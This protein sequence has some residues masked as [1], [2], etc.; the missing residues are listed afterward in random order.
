MKSQRFKIYAEIIK[1]LLNF[2]F[3]WL[4]GPSILKTL[5]SR[6]LASNRAKLSGLVG[7]RGLGTTSTRS[8]GPA[9]YSSSAAAR[10]TTTTLRLLQ[11]ASRG[12]PLTGWRNKT[13]STF[14]NC[15]N[16]WKS[17]QSYTME[18]KTCSNCDN[19]IAFSGKYQNLLFWP[20]LVMKTSPFIEHHIK[21]SNF[22]LKLGEWF[23]CFLNFGWILQWKCFFLLNFKL[24]VQIW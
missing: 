24:K 23:L 2:N 17:N 16:R 14:V 1:H 15:Q 13:E 21:I 10:A 7:R 5:K 8:L 11:S 3:H 20:N 22:I 6:V 19:K 9:E 18:T 12:V 4:L